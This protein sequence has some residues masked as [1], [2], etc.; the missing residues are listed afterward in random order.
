MWLDDNFLTAFAGVIFKF[1]VRG[2][3]SDKVEFVT[4]V[5]WWN[6]FCLD[7]EAQRRRSEVSSH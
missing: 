6:I 3:L 2:V 4:K 5:D 1:G 7:L